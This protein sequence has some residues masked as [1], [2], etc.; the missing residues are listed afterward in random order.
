[1][2]A[3]NPTGWVDPLGLSGCCSDSFDSSGRPT[4]SSQYSVYMESNLTSGKHYPGRSD[5]AH[6]QEGNR[7]LHE[8]FETDSD[9]ATTMDTQYPG[10]VDRV[11]PG[12]GGAHTRAA[13]YPGREGLT[14]HHHPDREGVMQLVPRPQHQSAG[15]VQETLH[16]GGKGGMDNWGGGR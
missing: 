12:P 10:I 9:F 16:P 8:R 2:Y 11:K 14:W 5:R 4:R 1:M 13:P 15:K 3:P 7:Q 6:F